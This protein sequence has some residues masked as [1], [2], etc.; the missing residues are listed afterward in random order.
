MHGRTL[1]DAIGGVADHEFDGLAL[2]LRL[3]S[4]D[5]GESGSLHPRDAVHRRLH[6]AGGTWK[7][8]ACG[9]AAL[10]LVATT[11]KRERLRG[12]RKRERK[13]I[14][15]LLSFKPLIRL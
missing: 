4:V 11:L 13:K 1:I 3:Q 10:G 7:R 12:E 5:V 14:D 15:E 2:V 6:A 9:S 8:S